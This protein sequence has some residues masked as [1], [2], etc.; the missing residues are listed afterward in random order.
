MGNFAENL[1]LGY[2]FRPPSPGVQVIATSTGQFPLEL[3]INYVFL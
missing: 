3:H 1:I 2:R